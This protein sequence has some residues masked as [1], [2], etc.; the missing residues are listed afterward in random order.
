[1]N[2]LHHLFVIITALVVTLAVTPLVRLVGN[3]WGIVSKTGGRHVHHGVVPRIGGVAMFAGFAAAM[4]MRWAGEAFWGWPASLTLVGEP[5]AGLLVGLTL[6]FGVGLLDDIL[7]LSAG[8]KLVGQILA[9]L[10]AYMPW[11]ASG[12]RI[13]FIGNPFGGGLL[14]IGVLSLPVTLFWMVGFANVIN[15]IDGLDGLAAGITAI[16]AVSL[17]VLAEESNQALA[18]VLAAALVGVCVGFLRYNFNPASIFMGD[19][20][21]LFLGFTL[22]CIALLGVMKSVA[23]ITL[24]VPLLIIGVPVFD[25]LSAIVRRR[26]GGRPLH[27]ADKGHVHHRLLGRGFSQRQTVLIIYVWSIALAVGGYAMRWAAPMFRI[28]TFMVLAG[29]SGLMAYWLGL[30]E[31]AHHEEE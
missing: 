13:D 22:A 15:L 27:E 25:T 5:V 8:Q 2:L 31:V 16:A 29:L 17:L 6:M 18:A 21:A 24:V 7:D 12:V 14:L 23:A 1:M 9:A 19:S 4:L 11:A 30:F 26:R 3:R 28:M 10:V 20:G